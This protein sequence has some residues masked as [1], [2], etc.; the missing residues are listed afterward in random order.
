MHRLKNDRPDFLV[1]NMWSPYAATLALLAARHCR[2]PVLTMYH[3]Y[4]EKWQVTG[5]LA[6]I[7]K[8]AYGF[9]ERQAAQVLTVSQKHAEVLTQQFRFPKNK[10]G[11]LLNSVP[12]GTQPKFKDHQPRRLLCGRVSSQ[13]RGT[14]F[15]WKFWRK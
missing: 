13:P 12:A 8:W 4:Q 3:Y 2:V 5:P 14:V 10:V 6:P 9:G 15:Y 1:V 7:K 11:V